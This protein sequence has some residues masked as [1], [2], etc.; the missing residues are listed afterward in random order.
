MLLYV[1][2]ANVGFL[3][4]G[5][6][7]QRKF[8]LGNKFENNQGGKQ[9]C[10]GLTN[11][12]LQ[13]EESYQPYIHVKKDRTHGFGNWSMTGTHVSIEKPSRNTAWSCNVTA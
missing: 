10:V 1:R 9:H 2:C 5:A 6:W 7:T 3:E 11:W 8:Y 4:P 13:L 12:I